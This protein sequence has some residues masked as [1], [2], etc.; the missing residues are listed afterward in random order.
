MSRPNNLRIYF[1][2]EHLVVIEKPSGFQIHTP[3]DLSMQGKVVWKNNVLVLLRKQLQKEIFTVH[4]LDKATS[5][6]M[7]FAL[8]SEMAREVQTLFI[9]KK[10]EK[11]YVCLVRGWTDDEGII[12][13]PLT[14]NLDG[15]TLL[16]SVTHFETLA[17]YE[18]PHSSGGRYEK[19]RYSL[20]KVQPQ[21]GRLHQ[22]R[23]HFKSISHPLVGDTI[24]G[25]GKHNRLWREL[26]AGRGGAVNHLLLKAYS[27]SFV[28]PISKK[29]CEYR[30]RWS[31]VWLRAFDVL[32][33]CPVV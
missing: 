31:R 6:V 8:S 3:V 2:D 9:Q 12:D 16:D 14:K 21:T 11:T 24:H 23:R 10:I 32:G 17:R 29:N 25:D 19:E 22:I 26:L 1:Q 7:L 18:I 20:V 27:I 33:G 30:S 5:G 13:R 15:G 28:H 4:R